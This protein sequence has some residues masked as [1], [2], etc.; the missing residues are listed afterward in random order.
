MDHATTH[1][2]SGMLAMVVI[3]FLSGMLSTMNLWASKSSDVMWSLNDLYMSLIMVGW[4]VLLM[5]LYYGQ[6]FYVM[7]GIVMVIVIFGCIRYQLS[8]TPNQYMRGMIPHHSMAITMSERL[9]ERSD[10]DPELATLATSIIENQRS[11]ID[12][13]RRLMGKDA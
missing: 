10:V 7:V 11:E 13:M 3:M 8:I 5:G 6:F 12:T 4:M 9:L 1:V 2:D